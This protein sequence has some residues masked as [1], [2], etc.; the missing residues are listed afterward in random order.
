MGLFVVAHGAWSAG[1]AWK[2]MHP[3]MVARGH[4]LITP[5]YTGLGERAHLAHAGVGLET[6]IADIVGVLETE[7]LRDILLIGHS[8]GGMVA[9]GVADRAR[10]RIAGLIYIDAFAPRDGDS[11]FGLLPPQARAQRQPVASNGGEAWQIPPGPM[12]AD[13][14]DADRAWAE[15]RRRPQPVKAFEQP[16]RLH[17]GEPSMPRHY[18][19]CA[20]HTPDDRFRQF[21]ERAEREGWGR[22]IIDASHNPHITAPEA[23]ADMLDR[24]AT[25]LSGRS[26]RSG[27]LRPD[28]STISGAAAR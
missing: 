18:I 14:S 11:V 15:P 1:W 4:R 13:T 7:D 24:I 10:E 22:D 5:T 9:T 17:H 28:R 23:L 21:H 3:L 8:Y 25:S 6:H 20:R 27:S 12:P 26:A 2:K 19:Y 16:L